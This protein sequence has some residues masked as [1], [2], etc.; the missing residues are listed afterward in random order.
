MWMHGL[1][2]VFGQRLVKVTPVEAPVRSC[3]RFEVF[4][5]DLLQCTMEMTV[6]LMAQVATTSWVYMGQQSTR[7]SDTLLTFLQAGGPFRA[8]VQIVDQGSERSF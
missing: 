2:R 3:A 8:A 1:N 7:R 6:V 5:G 4:H